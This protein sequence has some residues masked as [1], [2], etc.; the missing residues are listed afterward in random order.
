LLR[1][2]IVMVAAGDIIIINYPLLIFNY[3][4]HTFRFYYY[5]DILGS[6]KQYVF[7]KF[8]EYCLWL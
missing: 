3:S 5:S 1:K 6:C 4:E 8:G 2:Y 7:P